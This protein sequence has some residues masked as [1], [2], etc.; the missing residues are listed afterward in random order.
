MP[1]KIIPFVVIGGQI[2]PKQIPVST[3]CRVEV[4]YVQGDAKAIYCNAGRRE[5]L[6]AL[7]TDVGWGGDFDAA[8]SAQGAACFDMQRGG[9]YVSLWTYDAGPAFAIG[10]LRVTW[11]NPAIRSKPRTEQLTP[12]DA[13]HPPHT[14]AARVVSDEDTAARTDAP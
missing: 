10:Y 6:P 9:G 8:A 13:L 11:E 14:P 5:S 12:H 1:S 2:T 7:P 3:G 4:N